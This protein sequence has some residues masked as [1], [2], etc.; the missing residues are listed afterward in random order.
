MAEDTTIKPEMLEQTKNQ[1]RKLVAEIAELA[2]SDIQPQEFHAEF[3]NRAIAAVAASGGAL[4]MADNQGGIRL[5]TEIEFRQTGLMERGAR[6]AP[7]DAL[8]GW[9]FQT[10]QPQLIPPQVAVEGVP[11]AGNPTTFALICSPLVVDKKVVGM[12]EILMDPSRKAAGQK[13]TLRFVNDLC[14]LAS[15]YLKSRQARQIVSQQKLWNQLENFSHAIHASLDLKETAYAVANEGKRLVGCDRLSVA[16]K[17]GG[18]IG[19]VMVEATSG[20]EVVE[21]RSNLIRELNTLCKLVIQ[22]G[23]DLVYT[24]HTE[25][26][27][28]DIRDALELY[29]DE[30]GAKALVITLLFKPLEEDED[31][32]PKEKVPFGC[33]IAEQIGDDMPMTDAHSK[34]EVV[35]RHASSA[36]WNAQEHH[37]IFLMPLLKAIGSPWRFFRGRTG[38][39]ILAVIGAV[40]GI[41]G[42]L[43]LVPWELTIEGK[44]SLLTDVRQNTYAPVAG[45]VKKVYVEHG[46]KVSKGDPLID[47]YSFDLEKEYQRL[48]GERNGAGL[49]MVNLSKALNDTRTKREEQPQLQGQY[50]EAKIK[51]EST[52]SQIES[53]EQQFELMKVTAPFDGIVTTWDPKKELINRPVEIGAPLIAIAD[54]EGQF[55]LEVQVP[56]DDMAPIREAESKLQKEVAAGTK[57][58]G[59][60]LTAYF[61]T[62]A[63]SQHRY[64]GKVRHIASTAETVESKHVVKLEVE[65][66]PSVRADYQS[67]DQE[68]RYGSEVRARIQCGH[69]RLAYVLLR[70]VVQVWY[71]TVLFRW[72]FLN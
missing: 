22:S 26:F 67:R 2:E 48:L 56:D 24:G 45:I 13:S 17:L 42:I 3:L 60:A 34:T 12:L 38:A 23:E 25:T 28:P 1:I 49:Q 68:L 18:R 66:D 55:I 11:G 44:G 69:A 52:N 37:R 53:I 30:S 14:D 50:A 32:K 46:Q 71:E 54:T 47:L 8:L 72:P 40:I 21:Q 39:K 5:Q 10:G 41:I 62:A 35:S 43:A 70:D 63:D 19:K 57:P 33:L 51:F 65:F 6:T 27:P 4:W 16:L 36:L 20:Q 7:H 31:G 9:L 29:I 61:V 59:S 58:P 15:Q 64:P